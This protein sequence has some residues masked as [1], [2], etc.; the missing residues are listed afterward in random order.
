MKKI[1]TL[2]IISILTLFCFAVKAQV[3][4]V[5]NDFETWNG[6]VPVGMVG[7]K[8]NLLAANINP[9]TVSAHSPTQA[10][11]LE[12]TTTSLKRFTTQP[13]TV[14]NGTVY[15]VTY[16]VRGHGDIKVGLFDG[17]STG[18]GYYYNST[19]T[20]I[21]SSTW[22]QQTATVTAATDTA[23]A[24]FIFAVK[25]TNADIDHLQIDDILITR[26]GTPDP[27]ISIYTPVEGST[28][29][30]ADVP[31]AFNVSEFVVGNPGT[32][33]D[34]HINY[35]VDGGSVQSQYTVLPINL[36]GLAAGVHQVILQLVDTNNVALTPNKA[37]T[38]NFTVDL[39]LPNAQTIHDIQYST[40]TP[41]NSPFINTLT[42]TSGIVTAVAPA[43]YFIQDVTGM[44]NG[45]YVYDNLHHPV[46]GDN[47]T[48]T[49]TVKEFYGYTEFTAITG[50]TV[51]SSGNTLPAPTTITGVNIADTTVGE[52]YEGVLV[53][54]SDAPC[55]NTNHVASYGEWQVFSGD[56]A[57]ID[58]LMF[59]YVPTLATHYDVTGVV[60]LTFSIDFIEPRDANDVQVHLG[61]NELS[62]TSANVN[63]YPNPT[64][65][66]L[67]VSNTY[68]A[69]S[70]KISNLV[71]ETVKEIA[72][73]G[74]DVKI[75]LG[76]LTTGV[77]IITL[78]NKNEIIAAKKFTKE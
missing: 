21:N 30:S 62:S 27:T 64:T 54:I 38:V 50:F 55:S 5:S 51:V 17:R 70:V 9:Y 56:S 24:E 61:I 19:Y 16:W 25:N 47:V 14:T 12:N 73:N 46:I 78:Q 40:A 52:A 77:Y 68:G 11:K 53:T 10:C 13:H 43:G 31:V 35:T 7:A 37:D 36:T 71:G 48:L 72:I 20:T 1:I 49:G 33:I 74:D 67:F 2:S 29:Y 23:K 3:T 59:H 6:N 65:D 60:Y 75:N 4:I 15:T 66:F 45:I 69:T 42:T 41:A 8:T 39:T 22:A 34:G 18:S 58:D 44:W 63:V 76:N 28:Q 32:G 57:N 26:P